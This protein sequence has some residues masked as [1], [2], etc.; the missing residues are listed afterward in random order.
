MKRYKDIERT[1]VDGRRSTNT[2]VYPIIT[3]KISDTYIITSYGDRLDNLS[4]EYYKDPSLWWIIARAN[5][6]NTG[7]LFPKVGIQLRIPSDVELIIQEYNDLNN[8]EV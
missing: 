2:V 1:K 3:P 7:S 8:I 4:W 6:I 5:N